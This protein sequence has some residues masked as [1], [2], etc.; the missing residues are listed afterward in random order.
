MSH[1]AE[2]IKAVMVTAEIYGKG[3][4]REAAEMFVEDISGHPTP[5][6]LRALALCRRELRTFP[7]AADV[8]ARIDDGRPGVEEAWAML[9]KSEA[10]SV[11]W[12]DEMAEAAG[13]ASKLEDPVAARMAFREK[14]LALMTDARRVRKPI[15]WTPSL[16]F[17]KKGQEAAL[18]DAVD[19]MRLSPSQ[20]AAL[21]PNGIAEPGKGLLMIGADIPEE[22]ANVAEKARE[23]ARN[24]LKDAPLQHAAEVLRQKQVTQAEQVEHEERV[25]AQVEKLKKDRG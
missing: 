23:L 8:I 11:V 6:L 15:R 10:D 14:Y 13:V 17:D 18:R 5:A 9:P 16:G 3:F 21:L 7:T 25:M 2:L 12:T 1:D 19:R 24:I 4:S 22:S 20:A